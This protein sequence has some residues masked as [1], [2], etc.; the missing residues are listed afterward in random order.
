ML[1]YLPPPLIPHTSN[2]DAR[3]DWTSEAD[4]KFLLVRFATWSIE[5]SIR[6][7]EG[8]LGGDFRWFSRSFEKTWQKNA[9]LSLRVTNSLP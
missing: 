1:H 4:V 3:V 9:E 7:G 6:K 2:E 5:E 8:G